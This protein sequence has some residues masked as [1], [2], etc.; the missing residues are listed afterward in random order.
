MPFGTEVGMSS[1]LEPCFL[2]YDMHGVNKKPF[3]FISIDTINKM[4][5]TSPLIKRLVGLRQTTRLLIYN[6]L[7]GKSF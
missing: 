1:G 2:V 4:V 7:V 3:M 5:D 6:W